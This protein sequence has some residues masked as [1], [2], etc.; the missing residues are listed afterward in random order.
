MNFYKIFITTL[1]L[2]AAANCA[3]AQ[4]I[5]KIDVLQSVP[6]PKMGHLLMGNA[7]AVNPIEINSRYMTIDGKAVIPVMGEM[8]FSRINR[9]QW[10]DC[11]L[12]MKA[13]GVN[14]ISTYLFWNHHEEIEG[15]FDW[16]VEKDIRAFVQLCAKHGLYAYP[17]LG[18]W[19]HGEARNGGTP[20]WILSKKYIVDRS[21]DVVYQTYVKRYFEQITAQLRGLYYKDGGPIIGIQ[22]ENEYWYAAKGEPHMQW[23][24]DLAVSYGVDVPMYT[25]TGWGGGSVPKYQMIPLWG[26]YADAPWTEHVDKEYQPGNFEFASFRDNKNIG[27]DQIDHKDVYM[28]YEDYPYFTCEMGMGVQNTYHRRLDISY[29]DGLGMITAKLG[30]GSN[31]LGYYTFAGA[32]QFRGQLNSTEEE[33]EQTGYWSRVPGKS[34]DFQAAIRESGELAPSYGQLKKLHYFIGDFGERL[35]P[36]AATVGQNGEGQMQTAVR[37]NGEQGFLFGINYAR[38]FPKEVRKK[39]R[40]EVKLK[41]EVL[42]FP[43]GGVDIADSTVFV[44]P[45]N[46]DIDGATIKYATAQLM[47]R[48]GI[49]YLFFQNRDTHVEFAFDRSQIKTLSAPNAKIG[50]KNGLMIVSSL[51]AG[52]DC[53]INI[54]LKDGSSRKIIVLTQR[55]ADDSWL[56]TRGGQRELYICSGGMYEND[57]QVYIFS[58]SN[59]TDYYRM[60]NESQTFKRYTVSCPAK[61]SEVK[62]QPRKILDSASW[63]QTGDFKEIPAYQVRYRRF[64]FKEFSLENPSRVRRATMYIYPQIECQMNINNTWM[65]QPIMGEK[66]NVI[67]L[68]GYVQRGDNMMYLSFPFVEGSKS[69]AARVI[70]EYYNYDRVEFS[71]DQSWVTRDM[72]TNPAKSTPSNFKSYDRPTAPTVAT[73]PDCAKNIAYN[74]FSEWDIDVPYSVYDGVNNVY[75][76]TKYKGD[77]AEIYNGYT[78]SADDF[79]SNK[80]WSVGLNRQERSVAGRELRMV[81]YPLQTDS[82][83][84][85]DVPPASDGFNVSDVEKFTVVEEYKIKIE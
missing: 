85:F 15:Q 81:I 18:P 72:Y 4:N 78:L 45:L 62:I 58:S 27:N 26:G 17:R 76:Y 75:L 65:R 23:L 84:F 79:N 43:Q 53:S 74:G 56:L 83:I 30:S 63:L 39:S 21:N 61:R 16:Q 1:L 55:Q 28:T 44:W 73:K 10:E 77:R 34:Y 71:T 68:T 31:L 22:L 24:K 14:V 32:T 54:G 38:Y 7:G 42:S 80:T 36:M 48:Q 52:L 33:Q 40:F 20:D 46:F 69:F 11:I 3:Q 66:L 29:L 47:C 41:N 35:A 2:F 13:C 12:K 49:T 5:Y 59:A 8:H 67:D 19:S 51:K 50:E 6:E 82:K 57:G 70:V 64:F 37:S 25:V 60:D 9:N